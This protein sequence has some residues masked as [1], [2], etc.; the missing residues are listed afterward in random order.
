LKDFKVDDDSF[1]NIVESQEEWTEEAE[2]RIL[3]D[4]NA[5]EGDF[6]AW[7]NEDNDGT[8]D[9]ET[10]QVD[11]L[12]AARNSSKTGGGQVRDIEGGMR[13]RARNTVQYK[14]LAGGK[15]P[16]PTYKQVGTVTE[17]GEKTCSAEFS[18]NKGGELAIQQGLSLTDDEGNKMLNLRQDYHA[19][20]EGYEGA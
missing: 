11:G 3:D 7:E 15:A 16:I 9:E 12:V 8:V 10:P 14:R 18:S 6:E 2:S 19:V 5:L 17:I 20:W 13:L 1:E 4:D